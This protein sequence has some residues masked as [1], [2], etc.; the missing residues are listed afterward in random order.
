MP[1]QIPN[2]IPATGITNQIIIYSKNWYGISDRGVISD[3]QEIICKFCLL[4]KCSERDA[5]ELLISTFEQYV[6][7]HDRIDG[8]QEILVP[9]FTSSAYLRKPENIMIG[10]LGII[11]GEYVDM[12]KKMDFKVD[13]LDKEPSSV[14]ELEEMIS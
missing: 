8:L 11:L 7:E 2:R 14:E 1:E 9:F 12:S 6:K 13:D 4:D 10:K 5:M 3:L